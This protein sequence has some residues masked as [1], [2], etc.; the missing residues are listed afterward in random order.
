MALILLFTLNI[1][2]FNLLYNLVL[3]L[4]IIPI[5]IESNSNIIKLLFALLFVQLDLISY[6]LNV[7]IEQWS[8]LGNE[9]VHTYNNPG[10][11]SFLRPII[12]FSFTILFA[13]NFTKSRTQGV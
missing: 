11:G 8:Y 6:K 9:Y 7:P 2:S 10:L 12:F 1:G 5:V 3:L 13:Y 4:P